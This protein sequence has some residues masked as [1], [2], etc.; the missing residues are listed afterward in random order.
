MP[1]KVQHPNA[2]RAS[3]RCQ[4]ACFLALQTTNNG[5]DGRA[6]LGLLHL[7]SLLLGQSLT[8]IH[9]PNPSHYQ[10]SRSLVIGMQVVQRLVCIGVDTSHL[11]M[12]KKCVGTLMHHMFHDFYHETPIRGYLP[13]GGGSGVMASQPI[14]HGRVSRSS[15]ISIQGKGQQSLV[16]CS[17]LL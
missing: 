15:W 11:V 7:A 14:C 8:V 16:G 3:G 13:A 10:E 12:L 9:C 17:G 2:D 5:S 4:A 1:S 6:Y